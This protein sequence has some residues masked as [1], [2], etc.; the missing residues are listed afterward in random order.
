MAGGADCEHSQRCQTMKEK[1]V[2]VGGGGHCRS[3]IDVIEQ[4]GTYDIFG[5]VD[6]RENI[7]KKVLGYPIIAADEDI[8][9]I[10]KDVNNFLITV[11][12]IKSSSIREKL[13][14]KFKG[15]D[16]NFPV[17]ISPSAYVSP[18]V[19]IAEG[20]IIMHHALINC[21]AKIG[22]HCIIN[23]KALIEHDAELGD[24]CHISTG[25]VLNGAVAV[26]DSSFIGSNTVINHMVNIPS[27]TVIGSGSVVK[28]KDNLREGYI[29]SGNPI[30]E[31][32]AHE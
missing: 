19:L 17:I 28:E 13:V 5:I 26:G 10:C 4:E 30:R 21:N 29:Y 25:A 15:Y 1:I 11:G 32:H 18:H 9:K 22:M 24:Y 23:T 12:H 3:C 7:G 16:V 6:V 27:N 31:L 14:K 2:L 8:P 20:T